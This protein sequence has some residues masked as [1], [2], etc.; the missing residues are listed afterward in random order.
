MLVAFGI[1]AVFAIIAFTSTQTVVPTMPS[2]TTTPDI[3]PA[4]AQQLSAP[5]VSIPLVQNIV[6]ASGSPGTPPP[7][8]QPLP[9]PSYTLTANTARLNYPVAVGRVGMRELT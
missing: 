2:A 6:S 9:H 8:S 5:L 1:A 3:A 7:L 4:P